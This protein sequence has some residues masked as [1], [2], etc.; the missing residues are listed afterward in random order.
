MFTKGN[1]LG[2]PRTG[3]RNKK[4]KWQ[5]LCDKHNYRPGELGI[6]AAQGKAPCVTCGGKG[7]TRFQPGGGKSPSERTCQS[8][9][10]SGYERDFGKQLDADQK[11]VKRTY[12]DLKQMEVTG[13][14][15]GP[16]EHTVE[17]IIRD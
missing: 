16:L 10:G 5:E 14:D 7:K 3:K 8:C 1:K 15:G 13:E 4:L 2:R 6:L 17:L 9:W 12:P 11:N